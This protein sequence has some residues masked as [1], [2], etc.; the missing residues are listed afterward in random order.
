MIHDIPAAGKG[1]KQLARKAAIAAAIAV[2]LAILFVADS[3]WP[4]GGVVHESI[5]WVGIALIS[6]CVLGRTWCTLYIGGRKNAELVQDGPYSITRNPLYVF[7]IIGA[8]GVGAQAGGFTVALACGFLTWLIFLR[9]AQVEESAM[10]NSFGDEY[11][12]Y[13]DRVP[14]LLPKLSLYYS[15]KSLVVYP[16]QIAI[17]FFDATIFFLAVP[18][19]E[20]FDHLHDS[21]VLPTL[22]WLP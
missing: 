4:D 19:M 21:G 13:M 20:L 2:A 5:E 9:M 22:F 3:Y 17:T 1:P 7:S 8:I 10:L 6:I 11:R 15:R 18:L 14:R 12:R 16:R